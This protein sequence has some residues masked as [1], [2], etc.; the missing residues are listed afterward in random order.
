MTPIGQRSSS[1]A[2]TGARLKVRAAWGCHYPLGTLGSF[3]SRLKCGGITFNLPPRLLCKCLNGELLH[4]RRGGRH[5]AG[6]AFRFVIPTWM[7]KR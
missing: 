1:V 5:G 4:C 3:S 6:G 2:A 7:I